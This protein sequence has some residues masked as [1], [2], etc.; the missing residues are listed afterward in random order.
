MPALTEEWVLSKEGNLE[1]PGMK[2]SGLNQW[3][4]TSYASSP[5]TEIL[6]RETEK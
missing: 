4:Q 3:L 2:K 6:R 5:R 1:Q